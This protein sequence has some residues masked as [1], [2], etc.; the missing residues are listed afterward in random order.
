[1]LEL[2]LRFLIGGL[3]VSVF[4]IIGDLFKPKSFG[5][6]FGASPSIALATLALTIGKYGKS[7]AATESRSMVAGA[8]ALFV[9]ANVVS[10]VL[11]PGRTSALKAT[12]ASMPAWFA[13][14]LF[15]WFLFLR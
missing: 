15:G 12:L 13:V 8:V 2:F 6:L 3:F 10:R 14:A 11:M 5:G 9:Y 7:Y 1:M 4:A